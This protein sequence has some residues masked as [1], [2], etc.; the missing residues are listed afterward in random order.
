MAKQSVI[1]KLFS[2]A[3]AILGLSGGLFSGGCFI[4]AVTIID[5]IKKENELRAK[6]VKDLAATIKRYQK[7]LKAV[8][9]Q[10][11]TLQN[12]INRM[13]K[14]IAILNLNIKKNSNSDY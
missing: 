5:E 9:K 4:Y 10:E 1:I 7:D 12:Q 8:G 2:V 6:E 13:N 11:N 3:A 14:E